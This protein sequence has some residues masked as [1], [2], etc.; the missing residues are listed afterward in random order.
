MD[1]REAAM[2]TV[3]VSMPES[4]KEFLDHEV[5]T[6]GY[7]NVSEYIRELLRE[8]RAKDTDARLESLLLEGLAGE[9]DIPITEGFWRELRTDA[10]RILAKRKRA[11]RTGTGK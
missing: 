8:A 3:T 7:G 6:K 5:A 9:G 1:L 2:I 11:R 4:L 10:R